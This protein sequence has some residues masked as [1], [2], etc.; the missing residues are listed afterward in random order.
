MYDST[1]ALHLPITRR[2]CTSLAPKL[3]PKTERLR[4]IDLRLP[5][6][7]ASRH[8]YRQ[9]PQIVQIPVFRHRRRAWRRTILPRRRTHPEPRSRLQQ[10]LHEHLGQLHH[11]QQPFH[12]RR[13][14][15][16][17][18]FDIGDESGDRLAAMERDAAVSA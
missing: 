2:K 5:F 7:L 13:Y 17:T 9:Q 18:Q 6:L 8:L 4:R 14:R 16:R 1:S 15:Q 12:T 10:S 11:T 3:I